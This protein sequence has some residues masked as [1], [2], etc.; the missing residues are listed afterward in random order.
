MR[1]NK[2][3]T[4]QDLIMLFDEICSNNTSNFMKPIYKIYKKA[5]KKLPDFYEL[6]HCML[7]IGTWEFQTKNEKKYYIYFD[8]ASI[9]NHAFIF[10]DIDLCKIKSNSYKAE[11]YYVFI[12]SIYTI[13]K[14]VIPFFDSSSKGFFLVLDNSMDNKNQEL[15]DEYLYKICPHQLRRN[16][17]HDP[18]SFFLYHFIYD[19]FS[20][21]IIYQYYSERDFNRYI[22]LIKA[23]INYFLKTL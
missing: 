3:S 6:D 7:M 5:I 14:I 13:K 19:C 12:E 2:K 20:S 15:N 21:P 16:C 23:K 17:F 8:I 10:K 22:H 9:Y 1:Q 4:K 11:K 18:F